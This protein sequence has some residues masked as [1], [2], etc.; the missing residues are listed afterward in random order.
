MHFLGNDKNDGGSGYK[1]ET[2][3]QCAFVDESIMSD[4]LDDLKKVMATVPIRKHVKVW[5]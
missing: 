1:G 3:P 4:M 5:D 2:I